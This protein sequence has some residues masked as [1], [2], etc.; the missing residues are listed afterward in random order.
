[1]RT[2][3]KVGPTTSESETAV[4]RSPKAMSAVNE[5]KRNNPI[6]WSSA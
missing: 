5:A 6:A 4:S 3:E 1:M 2:H